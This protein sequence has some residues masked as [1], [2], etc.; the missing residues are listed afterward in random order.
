MT[1]NACAASTFIATA[2]VAILDRRFPRPWSSPSPSGSSTAA[3]ARASCSECL[4]RE[5]PPGEKSAALP[6]LVAS[7][8]LGIIPAPV[9]FQTLEIIQ[10]SLRH[11]GFCAM[12]VACSSSLLRL[13]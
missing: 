7:L 4:R 10:K 13:L 5:A 8:A 1:S 12:L 11:R 2:P 6:S 3:I 9:K